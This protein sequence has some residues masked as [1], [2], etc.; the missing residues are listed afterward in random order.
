[1]ANTG[2]IH[3][4]FGNAVEV[5]TSIGEITNFGQIISSFGGSGIFLRNS[6]TDG[7]LATVVNFGSISGYF[8]GIQTSG[9]DEA[10]ISNHGDIVGGISTSSGDD[11]IVNTGT[12]NGNVSVSSANDRVINSGY[13][14]GDVRLGSGDDYSDGRGGWVT[15]QVSGSSGDDVYL[16]DDAETELVE[17]IGGGT[18]T[19]STEVTFALPDNFE[20]LTLLGSDDINGFGNTLDNLIKPN[21]GANL[22]NG[23]GGFDT[24]SYEDSAIGV[25]ARVDGLVGFRGARGDIFFDVDGL[26]GTNHDDTLAGSNNDDTILGLD[27]NDT[28]FALNG[29]DMVDGGAGDD[30]IYGANGDDLL[31]GWL[32]ADA[33][34]GGNGTDTA[35]YASAWAFA[36]VNLG[37]NSAWGSA[38]GDQFSSIENLIG[39]NFGDTLAGDIGANTIEGGRGADRLFGG[40]GADTLIGGADNDMLNGGAD[41]DTFFFADG[42]GMDRV[43]GFDATNDLEKLDFSGVTGITDIVDLALNHMAQVLADVVI[44]DGVDTITLVNVAIGNLD[45]NDFLF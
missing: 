4:S 33:Y 34:N 30:I 23:G 31:D 18:D 17:S 19:V 5:D 36:G 35:S 32:G 14:D 6:A 21:A 2:A 22:V 16:I 38:L 7:N 24:V 13:V 26:I 25:G 28:I 42:F 27:G 10:D 8:F 1:L 15:G 43:I 9:S 44:T 12:I 37:A 29:V 45:A 39:S 11:A 20:N 3:G 41:Y 40:A